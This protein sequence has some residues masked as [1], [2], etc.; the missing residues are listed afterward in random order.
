MKKRIICLTLVILLSLILAGCCLSH[1]WVDATCT[2][3]KTCSKCEK[4]EGDA[5][6]HNWN[7]ATCTTAKTCSVCSLT[8]GQE[9]GHIWV[10]ATC[11]TP[12]TCITCD[13]TEGTERGHQTSD[14]ELTSEPANGNPGI[15]TQFCNVCKEAVETKEFFYPYFDMSFDEFMQRHNKAYAS[16]GW[17]IKEV[18]TGFSYFMDS[19]DETAIIF[20]DDLNGKSTGTATAYSTKKLE[21]FNLLQIRVIDYGATTIDIDLMATVMQIGAVITQPLVN[22]QLNAFCNQFLDDWVV[23]NSSSSLMQGEAVIGGYKYTLRACVVKDTYSRV[24]YEW[25]CQTT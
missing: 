16:Y 21:E 2:A 20:H 6:G 18:R 12:K 24:F 10:E 13:T 19:S 23:T 9:K 4:T 8:Q 1:E 14:W 17:E 25:I 15:K 22:Y 11:T 3:P 5:L 7:E